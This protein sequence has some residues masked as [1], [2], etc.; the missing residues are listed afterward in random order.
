MSPTKYNCALYNV[1]VV[2]VLSHLSQR[3]CGIDANM[4]FNQQSTEDEYMVN[5]PQ[6]EK[7]DQMENY[8]REDQK[9]TVRLPSNSLLKYTSYKDVSILHFEVPP[10]SRAAHFSFKAFE[11]SKS[12]FR[13]YT[14]KYL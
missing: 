3:L 11:E 10:D 6:L 14:F 1:I 12:T 13:K 9:L 5:E 2:L 4:Q 8:G 7:M